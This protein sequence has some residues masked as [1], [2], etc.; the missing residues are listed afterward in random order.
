M[1]DGKFLNPRGRKGQLLKPSG[2]PAFTRISAVVS[3]EERVKAQYPLM[4]PLRGLTR[5]LRT[6]FERQW[7]E[8]HAKGNSFWI[9]HDLLVIHNPNTK[10]PVPMEI[11]GDEARQFV[12]DRADKRR[13]D[14]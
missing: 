5:H 3:L 11:W 8:Y 14:I 10:C 12:L 2:Q 4:E 9:E 6:L 1:P 13:S 7:Q